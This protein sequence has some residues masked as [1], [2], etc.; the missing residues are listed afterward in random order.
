MA[1][2]VSI[3]ML[4][5]GA[6]VA[7]AAETTPAT[8]SDRLVTAVTRD[9]TV[10]FEN[11]Q[12]DEEQLQTGLMQVFQGQKD[13]GQLAYKFSS[14]GSYLFYTPVDMGEGELVEFYYELP[15]DSPEAKE[16][17]TNAIYSPYEVRS[18]GNEWYPKIWAGKDS[19][20][21]WVRFNRKAQSLMYSAAGTA[22]KAAICAI[23]GVNAVGCAVVW[24]ATLVAKTVMKK[25]GRCTAS[26][27]WLYV[28][29]A[30]TTGS[31]RA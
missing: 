13:L 4:A 16:L 27:P 9:A 31:C 26:R 6:G 10:Q 23:P 11:N 2:A 28:Y 20:G 3:S 17:S 14:D 12:P 21:T 22:L 7:A 5:F 18:G 30:Q 15:Q 25:V 29:P 19:K 24:G 1:A 8:S